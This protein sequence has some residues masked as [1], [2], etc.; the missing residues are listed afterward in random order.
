MSAHPEFHHLRHRAVV[1]LILATAAWGI[2]FPVFKMLFDVQRARVPAAADSH[3][4][5]VFLAS[6]AIAFRALGAAALFLLLRPRLLSGLTRKEWRQGLLLGF[7]G[8]T[9]LILQ[10]DALHYTSATVSAF[11][12]QFYCVL[13]PLWVCLRKREWPALRLVAATLLVLGGITIL[14]GLVQLKDGGLSVER[15]SLGRGEWETLL[16]TVFFT[17]QILLLE[18]PSWRANRMIPV[19]VLMFLGFAACALPAVLITSPSPGA[20]MGVYQQPQEFV[21]IG[22]IIVFCTFYAY[23]AMN[24]WQPHV[25]ATEAGLIYCLEPVFTALYVMFLPAILAVWT[26]VP[27]ANQALTLTT[28]AGGGLITAANVILQLPRRRTTP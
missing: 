5:S 14:S 24:R 6:H 19:S 2:S 8:G 17:V 27:Y 18:R 22:V 4:G 26:G 16:A 3:T 25:S 28:L 7:F 10:A 1:Q 15:F 20:I 12:T 11:L 9:G 23:T 13:L 21:L